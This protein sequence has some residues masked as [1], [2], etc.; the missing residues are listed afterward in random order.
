MVA[1]D[2]DRFRKEASTV[3]AINPD[4]VI[5]SDIQ[6]HLCLVNEM[7]LEAIPHFERCMRLDPSLGTTILNLQLLGRAYFFGGRYET[8]AALFRERIVLVPDTDT[9]RGYLAAALGHLGKVEEAR[10]VWADLMAVNPKYVMAERLNRTAAQPRQIELVLD[11]A[12]KAGL[13][14]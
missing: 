9:S 7:P 1:R 13:P 11:G 14:V 4:A 6:G 10:Q 2:F 12:R 8:A 3:I 5:A